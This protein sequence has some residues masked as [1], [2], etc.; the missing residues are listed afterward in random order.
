MNLHDKPLADGDLI[1]YR[2]KG[3]HGYIMIGAKTHA[4]A[5]SEA[6]R[7]LSDGSNP[8]L[9]WLD[10]WNGYK[11]VPAIYNKPYY[12]CVR[13]HTGVI[14]YITCATL[15]DFSY[16]LYPSNALFASKNNMNKCIGILGQL[17]YE[18]HPSDFDFCVIL[19]GD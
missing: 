11:Y 14:R 15:N 2:Y 5:L 4:H 17:Q 13:L 16:S 19:A 12:C 10:V 8:N 9:M 3:R 6:R 18:N 7:S 1:S